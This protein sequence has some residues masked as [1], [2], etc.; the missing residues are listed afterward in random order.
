MAGLVCLRHSRRQKGESLGLIK[1]NAS[2]TKHDPARRSP[3]DDVGD[4]VA[5]AD[6]ESAIT[7]S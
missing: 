7:F 6:G 5:V 4:A 1:E 3:R 2:G